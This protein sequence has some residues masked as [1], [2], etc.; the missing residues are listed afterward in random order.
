MSIPLT[1][2]AHPRHAQYRNLCTQIVAVR[3]R[4]LPNELNAG[5][6]R[7]LADLIAKR[8]ALW[9]PQKRKPK[10]KSPSTPIVVV[11]PASDARRR[12]RTARPLA[13]R[14]EFT[15]QNCRKKCWTVGQPKR[16]CDNCSDAFRGR[17]PGLTAARATPTRQWI[18]LIPS[19]IPGSGI[20]H[21]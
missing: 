13:H 3:A 12:R 15:C 20:R 5:S 14:I 17:K 21:G 8:D 7:R 18:R 9:E 11:Q 2:P 16:L 1:D 19:G 6:R 10:K 4:G